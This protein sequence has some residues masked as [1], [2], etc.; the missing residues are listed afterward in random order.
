MS[1]DVAKKSEAQLDGFSAGYSE[2]ARD[3]SG[4]GGSSGGASFGI[5]IK[6]TKEARWVDPDDNDVRG[7]LLALDVLNR[8]HKWSGDGGGPL[9]TITL[10]PGEDWPDIHA[11]NE[12]CRDD[13]FEKFGKVVGPW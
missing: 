4:A 10:K 12:S 7:P 2:P 3:S 9:E 5:K 11:L 1:N 8:V 6:F 13:W